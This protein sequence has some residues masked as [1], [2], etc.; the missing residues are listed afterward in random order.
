MALQGG[1]RLVQPGHQVQRRVDGAQHGR[2]QRGGVDETGA[3][4]DQV[5]AQR[6]RAGHV[7]AEAAQAL[8]EGAHGQVDAAGRQARQPHAAR[9]QHAGRVRFVQ[10][11]EGMVAGRQRGQRRHVGAVAIHAEDALGHDEAR[12]RGAGPFGQQVF[13]VRQVVMAEADLAHAGGLAAMVQA[14]VVEPVGVDL[15]LAL[16]GRG[17]EQ[18]RQHRG[19][20]LPAAGQQQGGLGAFQARQLGFDLF[21][22]VQVAAYQPRG[23]RA[24]A[25]PGGPQ[26]G[27]LG[28]Q[29]V[30]R[31]SQVVVAGEI[32]QG[33]AIEGQP[34]G[35]RR[36]GVAQAAAHLALRGL[37]QRGGEQGIQL[38][39]RHDPACRTGPGAPGRR[40]PSIVVERPA[41][42]P[43]SGNE[44]V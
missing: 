16:R 37:L 12:A 38:G 23:L 40:M 4:I 9:P 11:Q 2:R 28:Q 44:H 18:G 27:A 24:G 13:Q 43:V 30:A 5:V 6:P 3:G 35:G 25:V 29:R 33:A 39:H 1:A 15:R 26:A 17:L 42:L 34:A 21:V 22:Q 36:G 31:Q 8:A 10:V 14:G 7:G 20:G 32:D 19:V 41:P